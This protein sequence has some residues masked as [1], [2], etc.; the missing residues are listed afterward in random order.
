MDL[1]N[2][3]GAPAAYGLKTLESFLRACGIEEN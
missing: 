3:T 1:I 2:E